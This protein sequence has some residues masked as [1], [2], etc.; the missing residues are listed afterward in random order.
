LTAG[1]YN[2]LVEIITG[3]GQTTLW[4][5]TYICRACGYLEMHVA[6]RNDLAVLPQADGWEKIAPTI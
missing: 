4:V 5:D 6:N 2:S 3:K 1:T